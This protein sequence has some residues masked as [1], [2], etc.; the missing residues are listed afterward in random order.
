M[1]AIYQAL[2]QLDAELAHQ[3][4]LG[5]RTRRLAGE[6]VRGQ[7]YSR[8]HLNDTCTDY[9]E[10][11]HLI[12]SISLSPQQQAAVSHD[13][14]QRCTKA[15]VDWHALAWLSTAMWLNASSNPASTQA[16]TACIQ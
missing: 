14:L 11:S 16:C 5:A 13:A 7:T 10:G 1:H 15:S 4:E 3:E 9:R 8:W 12:Y 2:L 6:A